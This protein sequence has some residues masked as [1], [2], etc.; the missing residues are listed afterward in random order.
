MSMMY[1]ETKNGMVSTESI[2]NGE[3]KVEKPKVKKETKA[4]VKVSETKP[5]VKVSETKLEVKVSEIKAKANE[6]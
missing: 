6:A 1:I 4:K 2:L 3:A 5:E